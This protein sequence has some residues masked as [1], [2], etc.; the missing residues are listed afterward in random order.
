MTD[1]LVESWRGNNDPD[2]EIDLLICQ[3]RDQFVAS[4]HETGTDTPVCEKPKTPFPHDECGWD[5]ID[6]TSGKLLNNTLVEKASTE[7]NA[8]VRE[9][10][11]WEVVDR[12][13][14]EVVLGT[15]WSRSTRVT[16]T[17]L[18][19]AVGWSYR[20]TNVRLTGRFLQPLHYW[21]RC[22]VC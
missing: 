16:R 7:E 1:S 6:D 12:P 4:V 17:S 2:E 8:V 5:H 3:Q 20:S 9:L 13:R 19:T 11:V 18:S 14:G 15:R 22:E 10:G 21:R